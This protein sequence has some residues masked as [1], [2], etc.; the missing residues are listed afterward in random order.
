MLVIS[1]SQESKESVEKHNYL[2]Y[3]KNYYSFVENISVLGKGLFNNNS[4]D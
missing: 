2:L 1:D 3:Q 4:D